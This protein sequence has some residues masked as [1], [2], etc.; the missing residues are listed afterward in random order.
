M[1]IPREVRKIT[2]STEIRN[3]KKRL[4]LNDHQKAFL[5]GTMLG[6]GHLENNWSKT[7][8]RLKWSHS[9]K[10]KDYLFWKCENLKE[11]F[12]SAPRFYAKTNSYFATSISHKELTSLASLFLKDGKKI[13][14]SGMTQLLKNSVTL[15]VWFMDDGNA[16]MRKGILHGYHINS[17]SFT[18]SENQLMAITLTNLYGLSVGLE[19]NHGKYRLRINKSSASNFRNLIENEVIESMRYKL[20]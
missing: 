18:K 10:Q 3:L 14:P 17:Q 8:Y 11:W 12:L 5:V 20:G 9:A 16:I 15:A 7:N 4:F 19:K 6:D 1:V 2:Y 13:V